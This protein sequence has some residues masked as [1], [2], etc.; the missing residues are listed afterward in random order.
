MFRRKVVFWWPTTRKD[1]SVSVL[2]KRPHAKCS[3]DL[4]HARTRHTPGTHTLHTSRACPAEGGARRPVGPQ[5]F[6][7][8][9]SFFAPIFFVLFLFI[10]AQKRAERSAQEER[11]FPIS[12]ALR[13]RAK[14]EGE[15][16]LLPQGCERSA[17]A[18]SSRRF[19]R[20]A[21]GGASP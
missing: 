2:M 14:A 1:H 12:R 6:R 8:E 16:R 19:S 17:E 21:C 3:P 7:R 11:S 15:H 4:N 18:R 20:P 9:G 5:G 13:S 10:S